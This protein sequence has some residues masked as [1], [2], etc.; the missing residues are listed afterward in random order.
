MA[1]EGDLHIPALCTPDRTGQDP[2]ALTDVARS[3]HLSQ[4]MG[5]E[6]F[7]VFLVEAHRNEHGVGWAIPC[8]G[9]A[10]PADADAVDGP[11]FVIGHKVHAGELAGPIWTP[12]GAGKT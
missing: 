9:L 5:L 10:P 11:R 8:D 6:A 4:G 2:E 3:L 7:R 1:F 12:R